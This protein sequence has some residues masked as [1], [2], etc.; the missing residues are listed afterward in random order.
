[1]KILICSDGHAQAEAAVDFI[2]G[3]PAFKEAQVTLMGIIEH[4]ADAEALGRSL[5]LSAGLLNAKGFSVETLTRSGYPIEEI[6]KRTREEDYD[7]VVAG[8]ERKRGGAFALSAK[9]YEVIKKVSPSVLIMIG[10]PRELKNL[11]ISSAGRAHCVGTA[12]LISQFASG[13]QAD[14]TLLHVLAEVPAV[15]FELMEEEEDGHKL[16]ASNSVLARNLREE[17][18]SL[19]AQGVTARLKLRHGPVAREIL[20]EVRDGGCD[21]VI[22]GSAP[23]TGALRTYVLGDV[24]KEIVNS[25]NCP[26]LIVREENGKKARGWWGKIRETVGRAIP[27][28]KGGGAAKK[29]IWRPADLG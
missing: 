14:V 27:E 26:V 25:V 15:F 29:G 17:L 9:A 5:Q 7:V 2:A 23:S 12:R 22:A 28:W 18:A 8:A 16:L 13:N 1:M 6:R 10:Q 21:L 24:T 4:P 11:L 19:A 3:V 20:R